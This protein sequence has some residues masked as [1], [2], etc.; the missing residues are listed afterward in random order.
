MHAGPSAL[1]SATEIAPLRQSHMKRS[2]AQRLRWENAARSGGTMG[3]Q[4]S[5]VISRAQVPMRNGMPAF[6]MS[7]AGLPFSSIDREATAMGDC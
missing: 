5:T 4:T 3:R 7:S 1:L 6:A 2:I